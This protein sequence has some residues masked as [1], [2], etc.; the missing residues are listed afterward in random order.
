MEA[1]VGRNDRAD[2]LIQLFFGDMVLIDPGQ[3]TAIDSTQ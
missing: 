2:G 3:I 1:I